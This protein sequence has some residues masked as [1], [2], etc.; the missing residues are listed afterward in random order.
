MVYLVFWNI[1]PGYE[2]CFKSK[3]MNFLNDAVIPNK[4]LLLTHHTSRPETSVVAVRSSL[5]FD[6]VLAHGQ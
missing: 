5:L 4:V 3:D 2:N 6:E 1:F